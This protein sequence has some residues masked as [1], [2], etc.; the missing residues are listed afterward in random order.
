MERRKDNKGRVLKEGESQR[1]DGLYQYR[2]T[3]AIG[4]RCTVYSNSLKELRK[5]ED[6]ISK[7]KAFSLNYSAGNITVL[8]LATQY[9]EIRK[10]AIRKKTEYNNLLYLKWLGNDEIGSMKIKDVTILDA[11]NWAKRL[12]EEQK[13][14]YNT[15]SVEKT[16]LQGAFRM[17]V[18]DH[19]ILNNPFSFQLQTVIAKTQNHRKP[20]SDKEYN[21]IVEFA[22]NNTAYRK[23]LDIIIILHETGVRVG[24]LCGI[25][26][27]D[28]DLENNIIKINKQLVYSNTA[29][30]YIEKTKTPAGVRCIPLTKI[31]QDSFKNVI[32]N[33][34]QLTSE[35]IVDDVSGFIF[36]NKRGNPR[37][38]WDI[39]NM[40]KNLRKR[41][42]KINGVPPPMVTPHVLR[43]TFCTNMIK[44]G[45][46]VKEVQYLMG[47]SKCDVTLDVY[48]HA[49]VD[50][51]AK[52]LILLDSERK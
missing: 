46:T 32:N 52:K 21:M 42:E 44:N 50:D 36:I 8:E 43:H 10:N 37:Q 12:H 3:N 15:I 48:A 34:P 22:K 19:K 11:K 28:V 41:Y 26:L 18:E 23:N 38:P 5:E 6:E 51:I 40:F 20:L 25:T 49:N 24:E 17:A 16:F 13:K 47:H 33:R 45:L 4:K 27:D 30:L 14:S 1:K 9:Y 2:W 29:K 31:A 39:D 35:P 7:A